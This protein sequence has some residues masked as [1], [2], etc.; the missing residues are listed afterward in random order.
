MKYL[1]QLLLADD[2]DTIYQK[3]DITLDAVAVMEE[4]RKAA[5]IY[6]PGDV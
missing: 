3:L 4:S 5:G 6:F 2:Y 1:T